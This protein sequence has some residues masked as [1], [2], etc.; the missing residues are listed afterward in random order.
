MAAVTSIIGNCDTKSDENLHEKK[1]YDAIKN[2]IAG[3]IGSGTEAR[4]KFLEILMSDY[5]FGAICFLAEE[6]AEMH[7]TLVSI[8]TA[9]GG[10]VLT[11][12]QNIETNT[13][14]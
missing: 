1:L 10:P 3:S 8:E 12:L 11:A 13:A 4:R 9:I 14:P 2:G 7:T 6:I 5:N